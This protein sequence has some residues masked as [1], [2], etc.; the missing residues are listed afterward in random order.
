MMAKRVSRRGSSGAGVARSSCRSSEVKHRILII[1]LGIA[2]SMKRIGNG[3]L[4]G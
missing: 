4:H 1:G 2:L 3:R